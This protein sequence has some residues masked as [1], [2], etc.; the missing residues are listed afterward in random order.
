MAVS[1]VVP[2]SLC[3]VVSVCLSPNATQENDTGTYSDDNSVLVKR[4]RVTW[5]DIFVWLFV[6]VGS[7]IGSVSV[8]LSVSPSVRL[9]V[10]LCHSFYPSVYCVVSVCEDNQRK[11]EDNRTD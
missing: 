1:L 4:P 3:R 9:S 10:S 7:L 2:L 8:A 5:N 6:L 11:K